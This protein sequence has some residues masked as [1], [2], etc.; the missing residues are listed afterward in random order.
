[1]PVQAPVQTPVTADPVM[2]VDVH[3]APADDHGWVTWLHNDHVN[4]F[5]YVIGVLRH[6]CGMSETQAAEKTMEAHIHG[7]AVVFTGG[8]QDA[9]DMAAALLAALLWASAEVAE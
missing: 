2:H 6:V 8:E 1:M 9:K 7:A 4:L 3:A 5:G